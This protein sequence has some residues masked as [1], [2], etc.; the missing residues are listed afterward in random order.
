MRLPAKE[1]GKRL[2]AARTKAGLSQRVFAERVG[3]AGGQ[4]YVSLVEKGE[5]WPEVGSLLRAASVLGVPLGEFLEDGARPARITDEVIIENDQADNPFQRARFAE[6]D[7]ILY[8]LRRRTLEE[9]LGRER[10]AGAVETLTAGL[11]EEGRAYAE[12]ILTVYRNGGALA[13]KAARTQDR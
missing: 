11:S 9:R 8:A 6:A 10:V 5:K 13:V 12:R 4:A 1:L 7:R 2:R 3:W